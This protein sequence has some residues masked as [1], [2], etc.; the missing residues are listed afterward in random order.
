MA[1][2]IPVVDHLVLEPEPHLR[3]RVCR[4]C[5]ADYLTRRNACASCGGTDFDD[6]TLGTDGVVTAYTIVHRAAPGVPVPFVSAIVRLAD[7]QIVQSNLVGVEPDPERIALGM[8]VRLTT[9]VAGTD[10]NGVEAVAYGFA[11]RG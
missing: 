10:D 7:G 11:P 5:G 6:T 8:P 2:R 9:F 4:A 3:A 1:T